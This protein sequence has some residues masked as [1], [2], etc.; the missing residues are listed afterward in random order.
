[1]VRYDQQGE[2]VQAGGLC[3]GDVLHHR[4]ALPV[5]HHP[6]GVHVGVGDQKS[7]HARAGNLPL[8]RQGRLHRRLRPEGPA[9]PQ[10]NCPSG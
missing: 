8:A 9:L 6:D 5:C 3:V 1:G 7:Y 2:G 4:R 10:Q